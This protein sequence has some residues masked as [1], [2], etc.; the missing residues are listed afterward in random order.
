MKL[1]VSFFLAKPVLMCK[2]KSRSVLI[3][4]L[5]HLIYECKSTS[6]NLYRSPDSVFRIYTKLIIFL[7]DIVSLE[8]EEP[9][10]KVTTRRSNYF[11]VFRF[12]V[13][14]IT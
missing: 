5:H 1:R 6:V 12:I 13:S 14:Q 11:N 2:L 4:N 7:R 8:I 3:Q 9:N 10:Y